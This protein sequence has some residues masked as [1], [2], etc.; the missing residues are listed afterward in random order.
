MDSKLKQL[1]F[2]F[3]TCFLLPLSAKVSLGIDQLVS[4]K[5]DSLLKGKRVG[6]ITN[7]TA[8]NKQ[9]DSTIDLLKKHAKKGGFSLVAFFAP[10]HG[11]TGASHANTL[12]Q[13]SRSP[14][15]IPIFSL[16]GKTKRPTKEM[17]SHI[18]LLIF[19]IQDIGSRS[20]T[21]ISTLFYA[22]EEAAKHNIR[23]IVL[24]RPNPINGITIDG[25]MMKEQ[26]RSFVGY[27]DVPYCH[28]MTVGELA[29]YFNE[30]YKVGC[31]LEVIPMQGWTREMTFRDTELPWVPTSPH[32]PEAN[33][34]WY[35]PTTGILGEISMVS[36]GIGYPLPFK[37]IGAPW[38]DADAFASQLNAQHFSGVRFHP[39]HFKPFY[40]LYADQDCHGV[41]IV[42]TD[43][44]QF[45]PVTTQYLII[46]ML[47][48]LYP[49]KFKESMQ[50]TAHRKEM[51]SKVNGTDEVWRLMQEEPYIVWRLKEL[52]RAKRE[53]FKQKRERYLLYR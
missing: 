33:S 16:H 36:I 38:I 20:Y 29:R 30:E 24:D 17:L 32:I 19:D 27:I 22:M 9:M 46:G 39:F 11:L 35:Y 13:D 45:L 51:F 31:R 4:G 47:K 3:F 48:S 14:E 21:Y 42:I 50:K 44:R 23:V 10:E 52:D 43:D 12:I 53:Q 49:K 18:D 34:V 37:M 8:V 25:P 2:V 40:G 41:L 28:G 15:G 6:L 26:W 5:Y 7:H 1:L